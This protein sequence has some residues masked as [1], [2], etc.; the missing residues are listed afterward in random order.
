M[1]EYVFKFY[2]INFSVRLHLCSKCNVPNPCF[3]ISKS[4]GINTTVLYNQSLHLCNHLIVWFLKGLP[5]RLITSSVCEHLWS[6]CTI[7]NLS[8]SYG[9]V[10]ESLLNLSNSFYFGI[11]KLY[12]K[13]D[14]ILLFKSIHYFM[15][16]TYWMGTE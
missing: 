4:L 2:S 15:E 5:K 13:F 6:I 11:T 8:D 10:A 14:V 16:D 1:W 7:P 12:T 9:I 3:Q